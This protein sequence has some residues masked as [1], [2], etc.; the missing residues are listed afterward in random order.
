[1]RVLFVTQEMPPETGWGG[2]GTYVDVISRALVQQDAEVDV[3]SVVAGQPASVVDRDG[4]RILRDR[5]TTPVWPLRVAP[6]TWRRLALP[7]AIARRVAALE[8]RPDVIEAPEW[9]AE[10]LALGLRNR[11]PLVVRLH[12]TVRQVFPYTGQGGAM[13]GLDGRGAAWL[14]ELSAR[15]ANV[16]VSTGSNLAEVQGWM[17][18]DPAACHPIP[19][20]VVLPEPAPP[21]PGPPR[22]VFV[23]RLELRKGPELLLRAAPAVRAALPDARFVF[24]GRDVVPAGAMPSSD[25]LRDEAARLGVADATELTGQLDRDGV[26]EQLR[27]AAV[28]VFP[29]RWESF[30]NVV[31]EALATARAVVVSDIP[32]F[33][34]LV[35][36]GETGR[37]VTGEEPARYAAAIVELLRNPEQA[38]A[39]GCSGAEHIA[40]LSEPGRVARLT[41][42]AHQDAVERWRRGLRAGT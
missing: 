39:M 38:A 8:P 31:A 35:R 7:W 28:C 18:L 4:V 26:T 36:D 32:P 11:L 5:L 33:R 41:A 30:G 9:M 20:P 19:Y 6:D 14:E 3:L 2:I 27:R 25:W 34:E 15:R 40:G 22:V 24:V 21:A 17:R 10:G 37:I 16:V 42:D 23:G 29:S 12:S 13:R 1:M